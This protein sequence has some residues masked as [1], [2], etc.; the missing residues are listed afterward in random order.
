VD[1]ALAGDLRAF[2]EL[3]DRH[4][5]VVYR[6]A[7]RVVGQ[8]DAE[9]VSQ[10]SFLR[11]YN[12]LHRFRREA[13]FRSW[14]LQITHN[15]AL[16]AAA[17]RRPDPVAEVDDDLDDRAAEVREPASA[18]ERSE[19]RSRLELKLRELRPEHR[20]VLVLRDVEGLAYDEIAA[21]T[22]TPLGSV[23]G[24]LHRAR[25]EM[26]DILRANTYDWE[27]PDGGSG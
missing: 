23:K 25:Q 8:D 12:R 22:E 17:R 4:R 2:E 27:L 6:V 13:P 24:R 5:G 26:I 21:V 10:D 11:A 3:V 14:L 15:T 9:D 16:N 20:A 19:R 18:L 1:Q 7:A